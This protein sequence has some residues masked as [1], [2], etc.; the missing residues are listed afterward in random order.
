MLENLKNCSKNSP[1]ACYFARSMALSEKIKNT[2][3]LRRL[4]KDR[5]K[6]EMVE[7]CAT[8]G[9]LLARAGEIQTAK[10]PL[11]FACGKDRIRGAGCY[12]LAEIY[13]REGK[14]VEAEQ[15]FEQACRNGDHAGCLEGQRKQQS[16]KF[17]QQTAE[18]RSRFCRL[19][20]CN[21]IPEP[22]DLQ[23]SKKIVASL[24][25]LNDGESCFRLGL[26][27]KEGTGSEPPRFDEHFMPVSMR[28]P[29]RPSLKDSPFQK[30]CTLGFFDSC[31][32]A[33]GEVEG[34]SGSPTMNSQE[35]ANWYKKGCDHD[36]SA[37]CESL[38]R[39][40]SNRQQR[41]EAEEI[42]RRRCSKARNSEC[43]YLEMH[44]FRGLKKSK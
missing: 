25:E 30:G 35:A 9:L 23:S 3:E 20:S 17:V 19:K 38:V 41:R 10:Q 21:G 12:L 26:V 28:R 11:G 33:G 43:E 29:E 42:Y 36:N 22:T 2:P 15:F 7:M 18:I 1:A 27:I 31:F 34:G 14:Q 37:S 5:C 4:F 13:R 40:L 6:D 32:S 8:Y 16:A 39:V 44:F 24:C